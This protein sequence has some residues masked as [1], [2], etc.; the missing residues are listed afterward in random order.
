MYHRAIRNRQYS[1]GSMNFSEKSAS[2]SSKSPLLYGFGALEFDGFPKA[3]YH[4][5]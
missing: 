4:F 2:M 5:F 3:I 1:T